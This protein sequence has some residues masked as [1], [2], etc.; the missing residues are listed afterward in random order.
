MEKSV[1]RALQ[2]CPLFAGLSAKE[3]ESAIN[4]VEYHLVKYGKK[5]LYAK[6]GY[7]VENVDI[8]ISGGMSG[9]TESSSGKCVKI[10]WQSI[11]KVMTAASI[12]SEKKLPVTIETD[13]PT[14]LL[15]MTP[16]ALQSLFIYDP[17]IQMNFIK[18]VSNVAVDMAI[19][20]KKLTLYTVREKMASYLLDIS[21]RKNK[22][23]FV[24]DLSRQELANM[25]AIQKYSLQRVLSEF[26]KEGIISVNRKLFTI[27][28]R[29]KLKAYSAE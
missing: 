1:L 22:D 3:V 8:V 19:R 17:R 11:G 2:A 7:P 29:E 23:E 10:S 4:M 21:K 20:V 24:L 5:E 18:L 27:L 15:R 28:D 6:E 14:I 13:R 9:R 26:Q 12:F 25:F 16:K